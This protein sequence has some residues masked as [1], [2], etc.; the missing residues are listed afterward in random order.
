M[1]LTKQHKTLISEAFIDVQPITIL[2]SLLASYSHTKMNELYSCK[3]LKIMFEYF[4]A[5]NQE[6]FLNKFIGA[7]R[8]KYAESL[9][10]FLTKFV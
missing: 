2:N 4:I 3:E 10:L 7:Q 9:N 1:G 8:R 5:N 6:E